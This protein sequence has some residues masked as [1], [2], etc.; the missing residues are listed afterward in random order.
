MSKI[1]KNKVFILMTVFVI[2]SAY[3][4]FAAPTNNPQGPDAVSVVTSGRYG[5][6]NATTGIEA[7]AGNVTLLIINDT[8]STEAWQGYYGNV[9]GTITLDDASN[10]TLYSWASATP[11]GEIYASNTS[12]GITWSS[13]KADQTTA[14]G[15]PANSSTLENDFSIN[16][17][18]HDGFN[19]TFYQTYSCGGGGAEA[20]CFKVGATTIKDDECQMAT[21]YVNEAAQSTSFKE[22]IMYDNTTKALIFTT[23][24]E[25]DVNGF[26]GGV[27]PHDFQMLVAENGHPGGYELTTSTYYFYVELA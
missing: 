8:R 12:S 5:D 14:Y 17:T 23:L 15:M 9:T 18:D 16:A 27:D 19:E 10:Y 3:F 6:R 4:V 7:E 11:T 26:K 25:N 2:I 1:L 20:A 21:T 24:L 13:A 22:V